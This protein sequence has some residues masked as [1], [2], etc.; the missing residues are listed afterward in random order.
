MPLETQTAAVSEPRSRLTRERV[1]QAAIELA[2]EGGI[3]SLSIRKLAQ[4]LGLKPMSLYHYVSSK[5][6]ILSGILDIV[7]RDFEV[8]G[9]EGEWKAAI[10]RSALSAHEVLLRHPWAATLMM[11]PQ[12]VSE[13]RLQYM[14][15]LLGRL[16]QAGFSAETTDH[17]YHALDSHII[18]FTLWHTGYSNA[19]RAAAPVLSSSTFEE[20]LGRFPYLKEHAGQHERK[21]RLDEASDYEFGLDLIL[22]S[23]ARML[24]A[25]V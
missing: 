25:K 15:S 24:A 21:R 17:A 19:I 6:D 7:V 8:A 9:E 18:G 5:D 3:E 13:A 4:A 23:L 2:D 11:S 20:L 16:R 10:R 14:E 1:L 12:R 22:D